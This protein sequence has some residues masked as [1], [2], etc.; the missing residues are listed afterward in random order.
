MK[1]NDLPLATEPPKAFTSDGVII[2]LAAIV[3]LV[4]MVSSIGHGYVNLK[5]I[6]SLPFLPD[7]IAGVLL[8]SGLALFNWVVFQQIFKCW[9]LRTAAARCFLVVCVI[10]I[11]SLEFILT[12]SAIIKRNVADDFTVATRHKL[13]TL[14][15]GAAQLDAQMSAA[16]SA[17]IKALDIRGQQAANGNDVSKVAECGKICRLAIAQRDTTIT[18]FLALDDSARVPPPRIGDGLNTKMSQV[19][20]AMLLLASKYTLYEAFDRVRQEQETDMQTAMSAYVAFTAPSAATDPVVAAYKGLS[21]A[22]NKVRQDVFLGRDAITEQALILHLTSDTVL[23]CLTGRGS[24]DDY[25]VVAIALALITLVPALSITATLIRQEV[26]TPTTT[27][28]DLRG[29][30]R[31]VRREADL[32]SELTRARHTRGEAK[33]RATVAEGGWDDQIAAQWQMN[34]R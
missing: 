33:M 31:K 23:R 30:I 18:S 19:Q 14:L 32:Y 12:L 22:V 20:Q 26:G 6:P 5:L 3:I 11:L 21:T 17:R 27:E 13:D 9:T 24:I 15:V 2:A 25:I 34:R 8:A 16:Y 29:E 1:I 10:S 4:F 7:E 28:P